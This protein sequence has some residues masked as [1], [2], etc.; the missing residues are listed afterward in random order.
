FRTAVKATLA[1]LG[2]PLPDHLSRTITK[3]IDKAGAKED[4]AKGASSATSCQHQLRSAARRIR[5]AQYR[6]DRA[7]GD[8][9]IPVMTNQ[10]LGVEILLLNGWYQTLETSLN[11]G[12]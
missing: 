4:L 3:L 5:S 12:S 8:G 9:L 6:I 7:A 11:C 2:V 10:H 1:G